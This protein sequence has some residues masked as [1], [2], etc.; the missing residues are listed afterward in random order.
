VACLQDEE[1][2]E[3]RTRER[4]NDIDR[5]LGRRD[6]GP[7][8]K[9]VKTRK[10]REANE[11]RMTAIASNASPLVIPMY[12]GSARKFENLGRAALPP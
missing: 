3:R 5:G 11:N 9:V 8:D 10:P 1:T 2:E 7:C 12:P 6:D 4:R